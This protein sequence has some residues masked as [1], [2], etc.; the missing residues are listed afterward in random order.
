MSG[1]IFNF[2][3]T[4]ITFSRIKYYYLAITTYLFRTCGCMCDGQTDQG[5]TDGQLPN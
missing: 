5:G 1:M 2:V 4:K 3:L